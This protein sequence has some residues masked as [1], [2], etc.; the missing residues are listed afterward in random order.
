MD[1]ILPLAKLL[2][3][4]MAWLSG[5]PLFARSKITVVNRTAFKYNA[6]SRAGISKGWCVLGLLNGLQSANLSHHAMI[7]PYSAVTRA[8]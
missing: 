7:V 6:T 3:L 1:R 5:I 4:G 8:S 2:L